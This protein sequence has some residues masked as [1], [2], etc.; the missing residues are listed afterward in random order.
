MLEECDDTEP[1]CQEKAKL[2]YTKTMKKCDAI[3]DLKQ[4]DM[5]IAKATETYEMDI[6]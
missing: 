5:C 4:K 2:T 3:D 1:T 6:E